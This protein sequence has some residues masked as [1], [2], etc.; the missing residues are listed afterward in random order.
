MYDNE[1]L[2]R[3]GATDLTADEAGSYVAYPKCDVPM[4]LRVAVPSM[5]EASDTIVVT[6]TLSDDG[7]NAKEIITMPTITYANVITSGITEFFCPV[8]MTRAYIK[9]GFNI[10]DADAGADFT[11]GAVVAG[12]VPA[13]RYK[14]R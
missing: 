4:E 3:S 14:T 6:I 11:A 7:T 2:F 8:P 10:T 13:G 1:M 5:A 12:L 9:V